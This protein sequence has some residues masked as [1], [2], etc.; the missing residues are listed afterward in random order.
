MV[1]GTM[2]AAC[3]SKTENKAVTFDDETTTESAVDTEDEATGGD[4]A[5]AAAPDDDAAA[6][7]FDYAR[8][9]KAILE[10]ARLR[11]IRGEDPIR[12]VEYA[13]VDI[14]GDGKP[15]I[16]VR[17]D[18]GQCYE[19]VFAIV[20]NDSVEL[21]ADDDW[22]SEL[23]FYKGAVG[24][25]GYYGTGTLL[26]GYSTVKD[27]RRK[28]SIWKEVH[29]DI[30]TEEHEVEGEQYRYNDEDITEEEYD[31]L[32]EKL[33]ERVAPDTTWVKITSTEVKPVFE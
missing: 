10:Q 16:W 27:S 30:F 15:E 19:G 32:V 33:G 6:A 1:V 29:F 2:I 5:T 21:L 11:F 23:E 8:Y 13:L 12:L 24:Y 4:E 20:G 17:G 31:A 3:S 18:E 7:D 14:D 25:S 26:E 22:Y 28:Y 9:H